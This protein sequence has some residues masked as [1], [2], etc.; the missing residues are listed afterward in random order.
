[1]PND[2]GGFYDGGCA[3]QMN[4]TK[5]YDC[6]VNGDGQSCQKLFRG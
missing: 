6:S 2:D 4:K 1:M 5:G 3:I